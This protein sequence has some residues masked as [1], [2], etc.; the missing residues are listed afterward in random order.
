MRNI[1]GVM[2]MSSVVLVLGCKAD[3]KIEPVLPAEGSATAKGSATEPA[4]FPL[5]A[6]ESYA[7]GKLLA[8][9][10]VGWKVEDG[11]IVQLGIVTTGKTNGRE[12]EGCGR[13]QGSVSK[14]G[15]GGLRRHALLGTD[16]AATPRGRDHARLRILRRGDRRRGRIADRTDRRVEQKKSPVHI[17]PAADSH[18]FCGKAARAESKVS[19]EQ[20]M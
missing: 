16:K 7:G 5:A 14:V 19:F 1:L 18:V 8:T 11:T 2:M 6:G 17:A 13:G 20:C 9:N 3:K 15:G 12:V 10:L 4:P